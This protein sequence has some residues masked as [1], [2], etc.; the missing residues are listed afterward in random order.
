MNECNDKDENN[1]AFGSRASYLEDQAKK[2]KPK[3]Y[4]PP[5]R[6]RER[7]KMEYSNN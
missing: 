2:D 4:F 3:H 1:I 6:Q 7:I 5:S